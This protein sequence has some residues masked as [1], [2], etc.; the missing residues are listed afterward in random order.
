MAA[1]RF[2]VSS[3]SKGQELGSCGSSTGT[4][5]E[6]HALRV[7]LPGSLFKIEQRNCPISAK[8]SVLIKNKGNMFKIVLELAVFH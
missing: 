1:G 2:V 3:T 7:L 6:L 4:I 5:S 8:L